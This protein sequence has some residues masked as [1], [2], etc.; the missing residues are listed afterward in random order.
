ML[1]RDTLCLPRNLLSVRSRLSNPKRE[2]DALSCQPTSKNPHKTNPNNEVIRTT[3][4]ET[5][6]KIAE[7]KLNPSTAFHRP[8]VDP[9]VIPPQYQILPHAISW[10]TSTR[11]PNAANQARERKTSTNIRYWLAPQAGIM[12]EG[13]GDVHGHAKNEDEYGIS[14]TIPS[15]R[16][17]PAMTSV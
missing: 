15:R 5:N 2:V 17:R 7:I 14:Q 11:I 16:D 1:T 6:H 12:R 3:S 10:M 13:K 8:Q 9:C 4:P